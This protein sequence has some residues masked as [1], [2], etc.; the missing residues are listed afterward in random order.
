MKREEKIKGET[1]RK[2]KSEKGTKRKEKMK[3]ET[4]RKRKRNKVSKERFIYKK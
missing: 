3:E 2:R 1:K 4:K